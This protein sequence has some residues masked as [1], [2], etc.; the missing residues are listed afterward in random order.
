MAYKIIKRKSDKKYLVYKDGM[1]HKNL[2]GVY[3]TKKEAKQHIL[4][5][6][7]GWSLGGF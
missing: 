4:F 2:V 5:R 1:I 3:N 7:K 6:K